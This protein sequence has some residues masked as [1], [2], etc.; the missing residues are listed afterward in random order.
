[1]VENVVKTVV[2]NVVKTVVKTEVKTVVKT[3]VEN[4]V[5]TEVETVVENVALLRLVADP[6]RFL[7]R[8]RRRYPATVNKKNCWTFENKV[9]ATR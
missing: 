3:V 6:L 1:M 8:L 5:K 2:E 9:K 7:L 4:V